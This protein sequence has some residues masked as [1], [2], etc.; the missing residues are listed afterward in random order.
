MSY[1]KNS[2]VQISSRSANLLSTIDNEYNKLGSG[3][4]FYKGGHII[5][6]NHIICES[7]K[8]DVGF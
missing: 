6:N 1:V 4:V 2:V 7:N 8:L 5:T 3:F